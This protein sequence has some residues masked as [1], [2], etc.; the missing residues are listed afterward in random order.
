MADSLTPHIQGLTGHYCVEVFNNLINA[1][2]LALTKHLVY[3][4][5]DVMY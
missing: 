1:F 5:Q 2:G 3:Y 4:L